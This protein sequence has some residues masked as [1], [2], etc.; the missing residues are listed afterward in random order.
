MQ[1]SNV[2][3]L[4]EFRLPS[5]P[6]IKCNV[7]RGSLSE[8]SQNIPCTT[9]KRRGVLGNLCISMLDRVLMIRGTVFSVFR[10]I[11]SRLRS[12]F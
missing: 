9:L 5:S 12:L 4:Q 7:L 1:D 2:A 3:R 6:S 10:H 8:D 11:R